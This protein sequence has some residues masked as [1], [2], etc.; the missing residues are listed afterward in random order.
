MSKRRF[1]TVAAVILSL[2][3]CGCSVIGTGSETES[4]VYNSSN[5]ESSL[6]SEELENTVRSQSIFQEVDVE[7]KPEITQF[8]LTGNCKGDIKDKC[9]VHPSYPGHVLVSN[10]V[11]I[12]GPPIEISGS[13]ELEDPVLALIYDESKLRGVPEKNIKVMHF[14]EEAQKFGMIEEALTDE[15]SNTVKFP[16]DADGYYILLDIYQYGSVMGY[17]VAEYAY[18]KDPAEYESDWELQTDTGDIMKLADKKWAVENA[19]RFHVKTPGQL[20]SAVYYCNALSL[21]KYYSS[22][23]LSSSVIDTSSND[24]M[25]FIE[26]DLELSQYQWAPLGWRNS[27][28]LNVTID[29]GGHI[30]NGLKIDQPSKQEVGFTGYV[31]SLSMRDITFTNASVSG[32]MFVGLLCG[33]CH[34]DKVFTNVKADGNVYGSEDYTGAF[35]GAGSNGKYIGCTNNVKVNG[36]DYPYYCPSEKHEDE[37]SDE[38]ICKITVD[39]EGNIHREDIKEYDNVGWVILDEDGGHIL[40]RSAKNELVLDKEIP[41]QVVPAS[42]KKYTVQLNAWVD[43]GYA[44]ISNKLEIDNT[45]SHDSSVTEDFDDSYVAEDASEDF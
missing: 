26:D 2:A 38:S 31:A 23:D 4:N 7:E 27:A 5:A 16:V 9:T 44:Y 25:I 33:E 32:S 8:I 28:Y 24:I 13:R 21:G 34:G 39:E 11:G 22:L 10:T 29:G 18:E 17:D 6:T 37:K 43:G 42:C 30:I 15:Q 35:V 36:K 41:D 3:L 20:A 45:V 12:I 40:T 14:D 1:C 19:P